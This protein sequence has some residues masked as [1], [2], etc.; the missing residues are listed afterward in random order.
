MKPQGESALEQEEARQRRLPGRARIASSFLMPPVLLLLPR[1]G[2][3]Q[4]FL[5]AC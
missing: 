1:G 2:V 4:K 3:A 5:S